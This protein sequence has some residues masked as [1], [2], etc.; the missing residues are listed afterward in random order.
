VCSELV[1]ACLSRGSTDNI[2]AMVLCFSGAK[3][4]SFVSNMIDSWFGGLGGGGDEIAEEDEE[5]S[6]ES[7]VKAH[8]AADVSAPIDAL[9]QHK[10]QEKGMQKEKLEHASAAVGTQSKRASQRLAHGDG[11]EADERDETDA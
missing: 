5:P 1:D 6:Q 4:N 7:A 9:E 3:R 10:Q 2:T 8:A 11:S